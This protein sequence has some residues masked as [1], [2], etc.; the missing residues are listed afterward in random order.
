MKRLDTL[1]MKKDDGEQSEKE[2]KRYVPKT[3]PYVEVPP[4]PAKP[5]NR[6]EERK[7]V[8][9]PDVGKKGPAY[10]FKAPVEDVE[11]LKLV[12]EEVLK[13]PVPITLKDFLSLST[14]ARDYIKNLVSK[15]KMSTDNIL[16]VAAKS[17]FFMD[18]EDSSKV[19]EATMQVRE[20][21][22]SMM[23]DPK[24]AD[25]DLGGHIITPE[26]LPSAKAVTSDGK[27]E[28][29]AG[30]L[31][32]TDPVEQFFQGHPDDNAV[33]RVAKESVPLRCVYPHINNAGSEESV[34]DGGS[35]ICSIA[36]DIAAKL[37]IQWD[38]DFT[39]GMVTAN[40]GTER[41]LGLARNVPVRFGDVTAHLQ[42]H[43]MDQP[44]YK[45]LLGLPFE[46]LVS[47]EVKTSLDGSQTLTIQD[48]NNGNRVVVPTFKRGHIPESLKGASATRNM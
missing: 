23:V 7:K 46:T 33:L 36:K 20:A 26:E 3:L 17:Q 35:Q 24:A 27:G 13:L 40:K 41:T 37:G 32:C 12:T 25:V 42:F 4:L 9:F 18:V 48:P 5:I 8:P 34:M 43:V 47:S 1:Q 38:P 2:K 28:L 14:G 39:I 29:P 15:K 45:V 19:M 11:S 16:N 44:A 31:V 22:E 10:V 21:M 6:F 30:S